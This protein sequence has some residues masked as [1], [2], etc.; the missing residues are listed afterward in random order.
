MCEDGYQRARR[1]YGDAHPLTGELATG[2]DDAREALA[3]RTQS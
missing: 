3:R 1:V 2:L